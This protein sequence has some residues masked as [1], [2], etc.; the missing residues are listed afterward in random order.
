MKIAVTSPSFSKH[1][2][3]IEKI[4]SLFDAVKLNSN[5]KIFTQ[6]EL[7]DYLQGYEAVIVGLDE[8]NK[9]V[10]DALPS[11]K[12]ISKYGVGLNNIDLDYSNEKHIVIGWTGGVNKLSVAEMCVGN[13]LSL[14]RNMGPSSK[15]LARGFWE[16]SGGEQLSGKRIGIIG[17]GFIGKEM[18][19]LLSPFRCE[20]WV[21]DLEYDQQFVSENNLIIK[22]KEEIYESCKVITLHIP[23]TNDT[24]NLIAASELASMQDGTILINSSRGGMIDE[25]ALYEELKTGRLAAAIDVFQVEPPVNLDLLQLDNLIATPHIGGSSTEAIVAMGMSAISHIENFYN[26]E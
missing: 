18:V 10:I 14:I 5:G 23:F 12:I 9:V 2:V 4:N 6:E 24:N 22:A 11:L 19:R 7:I 17:L 25:I 16:K 15:K 3:L 20:I 8:I 13:I 21:N 1:P 26:L